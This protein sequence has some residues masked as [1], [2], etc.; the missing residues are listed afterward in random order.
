M[1]KIMNINTVHEI[2]QKELKVFES[3]EDTG[4]TPDLFESWKTRIQKVSSIGNGKCKRHLPDSQK[5]EYP[6]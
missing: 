2:L 1:K 6:G 4:V 5:L 3:L